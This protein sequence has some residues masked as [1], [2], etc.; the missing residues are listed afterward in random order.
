MIGEYGQP[1]TLTRG[2][3][4]GGSEPEARVLGKT[5]GK[6]LKYA[7]VLHV[8]LHC[9][10]D[11]N[12]PFPTK[13]GAS[14]VVL[15][16]KLVRYANKNQRLCREQYAALR[17]R[18]AAIMLQ[19]R[20]PQTAGPAAAPRATGRFTMR[21]IDVQWRPG[22]GDAHPRPHSDAAPS[23][24]VRP[25]MRVRRSRPQDPASAERRAVSSRTAPNARPLK[26]PTRSCVRRSRPQ[27]PSRAAGVRPA[28]PQPRGARPFFGGRFSRPLPAITAFVDGSPT[29]A[30]VLLLVG[31]SPS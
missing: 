28:H 27:D 4:N 31:T 19:E 18:K 30:S 22:H 25:E 1:P 13:I 29:L 16:D 5:Q 9:F 12:Q 2:A 14:S 6:I 11:P 26:P 20:P 23:P 21:A 7:A 17:E 3:L 24:A 10:Q 15:A 8:F